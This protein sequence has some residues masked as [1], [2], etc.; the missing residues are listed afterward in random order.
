MQIKKFYLWLTIAVVFFAL[1]GGIYYYYRSV[2]LD[3][4]SPKTYYKIF[5]KKE[6]LDGRETTAQEVDAKLDARL[7]KYHR[8]FEK[9]AQ[10]SD[11][12]RLRALFYM[13]FVHMYG[14]YGSR[15]LKEKTLK[16][17]LTGSEYFHCGTNT[18]FLA[19]LLDK[20][21][22]DFRTVSIN[23]FQHGYVEVNF[24]GQYNLL[25]PTVNLWFDKSTEEIIAGEHPVVKAFFMQAEDLNNQKAREHLENKDYKCNLF[26]LKNQMLSIGDKFKVKID[27]YN[28]IDL[29]EYQY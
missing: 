8:I 15:N 24:N 21:G 10:T 20:A 4:N 9:I 26:C 14:Y 13:N 18:T 25:D 1:A 5:N 11:E 19:M 7:K 17:I 12:Q 23:D 29:S 28:Y 3:P 6:I 16:E 2:N 22:F 27:Q